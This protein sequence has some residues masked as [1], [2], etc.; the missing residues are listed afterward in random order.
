MPF[1]FSLS[2]AKESS[3]DFNLIF[4]LKDS[5][6]EGARE[7]YR[8]HVCK[9]CHGISEK[10]YLHNWRSLKLASHKQTY[11]VCVCVRAYNVYYL[12]EL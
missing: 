11:R 5:Q 9:G 12:I 7:L 4:R 1:F 2:S 6:L 8:G 10:Q 3:M